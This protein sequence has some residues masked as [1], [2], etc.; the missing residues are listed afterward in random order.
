MKIIHQKA[1]VRFAS[2]RPPARVA[3]LLLRDCVKLRHQVEE[4]L[5]LRGIRHEYEHSPLWRLPDF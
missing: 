4:C 1:N 5:R 2:L 3:R